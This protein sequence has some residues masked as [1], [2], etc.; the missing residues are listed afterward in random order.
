MGFVR[1]TGRNRRQTALF[2]ALIAISAALLLAAGPA[3]AALSDEARAEIQHQRGTR[4]LRAGDPDKA[5]EWFDKALALQPDHIE[6]M[7]MK[8]RALLEAG[9]AAEA[10]AVTQQLRTLRPDDHEVAYLLG[11]TAY[12]QQDWISA[13]RYLEE[14]RDA[15]PGDA[16]VRLYLGRVYQELGQDSGAERELNEAIRLQPELRAPATF[17]L[18]ILHLQR[19][20]N[21]QAKRLFK[22]VAEIDRSSELASQAELYL[23]LMSGTEQRRIGFWLKLGG[24]WDSNL[25]L[26]GSGDLSESSGR[27]GV[28]S[29]VEMGLNA[30]LFTWKDVTVRAGMTNYISYYIDQ[31]PDDFD[32]QQTR[33]WLLASWQ[34]LEWLAFDTRLTHERVYR[35]Y[36]TFKTANFISPAI[37]I[38]PKPGWVTRLFVE[39]E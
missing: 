4:A 15:N 32:I 5:I 26:A 6:S 1:P 14:A 2:S 35:D 22:E 17:R 18:A 8:A 27:N 29:S 12:R 37:R 11:L 24:A 36:H 31:N 38:L 16:N 3:S 7:A 21:K 34:P 13:Q 10:E 28:R 19:G 33:P 30:R 23:K 9:R 39:Y 20:E 25:T